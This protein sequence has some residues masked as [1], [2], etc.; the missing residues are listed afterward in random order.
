MK[1]RSPRSKEKAWTGKSGR[2]ERPRAEIF[3]PGGEGNYQFDGLGGVTGKKPAAKPAPKPAK[4]PSGN[5]R[6]ASPASQS[7][8]LAETM[9]SSFLDRLTA[10]ARRK[11]G[12]LSID[13][14][15][16]L[17]QEFEKKAE[18]LQ[19]VFEK[20]FEEYVRVREQAVWDQVRSYPFDR[21]IVKKV[22]HLFADGKGLL[23]SDDT[24]SRRILPGFFLALGMMLGSDAVEEYQNKCRKIIDKIRV[25]KGESF[26]W[27][28]LYGDQEANQVIL[29]A[30]IS[31]ASHFEDLDKRIVWF[32]DLINGHLAPF[33]GK[34]NKDEA[35][36]TFTGAA[37]LRFLN[38]LFADL[39]ETLSTEGGR[40]AVSKRYGVDVCVSLADF[41]RKL[42]KHGPA[43]GKNK[44]RP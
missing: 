28:D 21:M 26:D 6:L 34:K 15:Q 8:A 43:G 18:A 1:E 10:E 32:T 30:V 17:E 9:V 16:G 19:V 24:V 2:K 33:D 3:K 31:L 37:C 39:R 42:E 20:S 12:V 11:G 5:D 4:S 7:Q 27:Q 35:I 36:W 23:E 40:L 13:D 29:D 14:L 22:S 44:A 25:K 38:A 41:L